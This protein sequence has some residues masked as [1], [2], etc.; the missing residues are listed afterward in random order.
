MK[1]DGKSMEMSFSCSNLAMAKMPNDTFISSNRP[2]YQN[3]TVC[4]LSPNIFDSND[5]L[6]S[7]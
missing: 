5:I 3:Q 4:S 1:M 2:F 7:K 6:H